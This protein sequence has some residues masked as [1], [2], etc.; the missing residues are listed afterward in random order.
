MFNR[1]GYVTSFEENNIQFLTHPTSKNEILLD[2]SYPV[3][4]ATL[5]ERKISEDLDL[6]EVYFES[7][8]DAEMKEFLKNNPSHE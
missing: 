1:L 8:F 6:S 5:M 4:V 7:I 3:I 2:T